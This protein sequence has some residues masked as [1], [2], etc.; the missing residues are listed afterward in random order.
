MIA[1]TVLLA[2]TSLQSS[3]LGVTWGA[4]Y[5]FGKAKALPFMPQ[6]R[7]LGA[8]FSRV[9]LYW[10]QLEPKEGVARWVDLDAYISQISSPEEAILTLA[11][12]SSWATRTKTWVFPSSPA[13]DAAKYTAFVRNVVQHAKGK[14]RY[15]QND[16]EPN[17][18]FFWSG[19]AEEFAAQQ[20][21][22]YRAVKEADPSATVI[23]GG[24]D[25]LFDQT[26]TDPFP[27]QEADL[28]F[29]KKVIAIAGDSYD[30]FDLHLYGNPYTIPERIAV[31]RDMM[32]AV[33]AEKPIIAAEYHGPGFFEFKANRRWWRMLLGPEAKPDAVS[34]LRAQAATLPVETR[35][36]LDAHDTANAERLRTL[37]TED[38]VVRNTIALSSGIQR[39]AFFDL[40]HDSAEAN[41][42]NAMLYGAF[43]LL[44]HD[45]NEALTKEL[46][47][48]TSFLRFS[49]ALAGQTRI[50]RIAVSAHPDVYAFRVER[51]Q[52]SP[53]LVVWRRPV[54]V[55]GSAEVLQ[56]DLP[57]K[58][59]A[60]QG[61]T[62]VGGKADFTK[63]GGTLSVLVSEMP[64]FID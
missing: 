10:S 3:P 50:S 58:E 38:I 1:S 62:A 26:N 57:W 63:K 55:G 42:A 59:K 34:Q 56:V 21:L 8:S 31:V 12:A 19:T 32:R 43:K 5:G 37:Q 22:F 36:F 4:T 7:K 24:C 46:P 2:E 64:I 52:R 18:P 23:L 11:S 47:L 9:T 44:D 53:L 45:A 28:A 25:G 54:D 49:M 33:G 35:M 51:T 27:G 13:L 30:L 17:N 20:R 6:A 48:A 29:W 41:A 60:K 39:T 16:N 61:T 40:W 15:F 14:V